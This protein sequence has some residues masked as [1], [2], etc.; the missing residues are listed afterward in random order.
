M[1]KIYK[2]KEKQVDIL[3]QFNDDID[4]L[5]MMGR[6][7]DTETDWDTYVI[8]WEWEIVWFI[9]LEVKGYSGTLNIDAIYIS[10]DY[11]EQDIAY[12]TIVQLMYKYGRLWINVL[13]AEIISTNT[14]SLNLFKK[15]WFETTWRYQ[16]YKG[17]KKKDIRLYHDLSINKIN[18]D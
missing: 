5:L 11:R 6:Y 15:L 8:E 1:V 7:S 4:A 2:D 17:G 16:S 13:R 12:K 18:N 10:K 14:P 3:R 9:D